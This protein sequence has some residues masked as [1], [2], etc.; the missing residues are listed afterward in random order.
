MAIYST[1]LKTISRSAGRS[2]TAAAAYRLGCVVIDERQGL[3]HDY[4]R[5]SGVAKAF[6]FAPAGLAVLDADSL[7][8]RA[9]HAEKRKNS[10]VARELLVALPHE[11][12]E[13]QR[14]DLAAS[15]A[16]A[17]ADRYQVAGSVGV[18]LPDAEGDNRN[19]HAHILFTTREIHADGS[20]GAKTRVLD[21]QKTGP[22]ETVW[23]R[24]MV[25]DLTNEALARAGLDARVDCRSL[26]AQKADA[27]ER[28]D[29][30]AA[31][32]LDRLP[33]IHEGPAVTQIRREMEKHGR[34][35]L[36][37]VDRIAENDERELVK[38]TKVIDFEEAKEKLRK[39][40]IAQKAQR[41]LGIVAASLEKAREIQDGL[42]IV[43]D[44]RPEHYYGYQ[45]AVSRRD[46]LQNEIETKKPGLMDKLLGFFGV[47]PKFERELARAES[48]VREHPG[49]EAA[50][51]F[52]TAEAEKEAKRAKIAAEI[53]R[54]KEVQRDN[55]RLLNK[56]I[57]HLPVIQKPVISSDPRS[58]SPDL[59]RRPKRQWADIDHG[60]G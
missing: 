9:E 43:I 55:R 49:R 58:S 1:S 48:L 12:E 29:L 10:T 16:Q 4:S 6:G 14:A 11:L 44:W 17:L 24:Q 46:Q 35:A 27:L 40:R 20:L 13:A 56:Y 2:A 38:L 15:I 19:H 23:M 45:S 32:L 50:L 21:D 42:K 34:E 51:L 54:L 3:I 37:P 53:E 25:E 8:N 5:R 59:E 30:E 33:A 57:E 26:E 41:D 39:R 28:G 52:D 31:E 18:H 22:A 60:Y 7:W 47:L 36:S